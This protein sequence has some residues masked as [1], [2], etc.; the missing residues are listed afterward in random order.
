VE[1]QLVEGGAVSPSAADTTAAAAAG[2]CGALAAAA[3]RQAPAVAE[4][5][6]SPAFLPCDD[7]TRERPVPGREARTLCLCRGGREKFCQRCG[8]VASGASVTR[9]S[10]QV[11]TPQWLPA[12]A[13]VSVNAAVRRHRRRT[14]AK[15]KPCPRELRQSTSRGTDAGRHPGKGYACTLRTHAFIDLDECS[16]E[17]AIHLMHVN[18]KQ[19]AIA[20]CWNPSS[21][22]CRWPA[23]QARVRLTVPMHVHH[24]VALGFA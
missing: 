7:T 5:V 3:Q 11:K 24:G 23:A 14:D 6:L 12:S 13:S 4:A 10:R 16:L 15:F 21:S 8:L 19:F 2:D 18:G 20:L 22:R 1:P 9:S 17:A